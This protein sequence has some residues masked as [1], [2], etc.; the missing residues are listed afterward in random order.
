MR[1][2]VRDLN[3]GYAAAPALW[4]RDTDPA[5][6]SWIDGDAS[7]DNVFAFAR[8]AADGSPLIS[9]TNF[10]PVVRHAFRLGVPDEIP[11]WREILNT[12]EVRYGGSGV[13]NDEP[14][15]AEP[16]PS[17]GRPAS[18]APTLPPLATLWFRPA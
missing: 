9:V 6:F 17:H 16:T 12:D 1:D 5:G 11:A 10:S 8:F 7:E 2:L 13:G 14:L 4:E 18:I 3:R 15:K